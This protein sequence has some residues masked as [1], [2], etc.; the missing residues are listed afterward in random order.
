MKNA[1]GQEIFEIRELFQ[2]PEVGDVIFD[3]LKSVV[4]HL[5]I[6]KAGSSEFIRKIIG[7]AKTLDVFGFEKEANKLLEKKG[8]TKA[9]PEKLLFR[10]NIIYGQVRPF[11]QGP[12]IMDYGCGD[13]KV[14]E[15][16]SKDGLQVTLS[17]VYRH[18]HIPGTGLKFLLASKDDRVE[19]AD[20]GF[21]TILLATVLHHSENPLRV[22]KEVH[23]I[24]RPGGKV[25]VI[26]DVYGVTGNELPENR[27]KKLEKFLKLTHEHQRMVEIFFDHFYNRVLFYFEDPSDKITVPYNYS[28]PSGWRKI[29]EDNGFDVEKEIH[30]GLDQPISAIYH[31]LYVLKTEK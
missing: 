6:P 31:I 30:L 9:Y 11:V 17:D 2:H 1:F 10:T 14:G 19:A 3:F 18:K 20:N 21:D 22:L 28:T 15:K 5:G 4:E 16:L 24:T 23:R 12:S 25:L 29:F 8:L 7:L 26:E 27:R 13:G